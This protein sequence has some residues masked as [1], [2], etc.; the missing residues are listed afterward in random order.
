MILA[1]Y[2]P[3][4]FASVW[5]TLQKDCCR[6]YEAECKTLPV[7]HAKI[8]AHLAAK[9]QLPQGLVDAIGSH[10][11]YRPECKNADFTL[12]IY[13]ANIIVNSYDDNPDCIIDIAALHP[14]ARKL[15]MKSLSDVGG[16]YAG[17]AE[18]IESA[19]SFFLDVK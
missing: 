19:Y 5:N 11:D 10:H 18:E 17:I 13:L 8:G 3:E 9:W 4:I 12:V 2:F 15:V 7:N 6:F 1:Q 14:D 16:W